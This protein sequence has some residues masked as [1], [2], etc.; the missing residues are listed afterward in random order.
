METIRVEFLSEE[1]KDHL[2]FAF[3][4]KARIDDNNQIVGYSVQSEGKGI[5]DEIVITIVRNWLRQVEE[6]YYKKFTNE[7]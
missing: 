6:K 5:P 3:G 1:H 7:E 2:G 4:I